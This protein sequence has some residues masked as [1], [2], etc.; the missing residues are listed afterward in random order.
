MNGIS[1]KISHVVDSLEDELIQFTQ[2]L[3]QT[4][5]LPGEERGIQDVVAEK[6]KE[7]NLDVD[8]IPL[9]FDELKDHPA[10]CDD[11]FPFDR[12]VNVVGRW[13]GSQKSQS[14]GNENARSLIL[15][16][17]VDVV[18]PGNETLWA[19]SPWS[20]K[21]IDGKL[22]GRGSCDMKAGLASGIFAIKA[23]QRL[24]YTPLRDVLIESVVG[25]ETGGVG[26][27]NTIIKGYT[28]DAAIIMEPTELRL[29][30][31]QSGALTFRIKVPGRSVHACMKN[32][33]ISSIDKFYLIYNAINEL[34]RQR[35]LNYSNRLYKDPKN[36]APINFGTI[37]AGD[38]PSTVPDE[39]LVE[40]RYGI[41]SGETVE[42][43]KKAFTRAVQRAAAG[44]AWL[45]D[46]PPIIE[47]F[48]GQFE[49]GETD[50]NEPVIQILSETHTIITGKEA[51]FQGVTYGSDLRLF[52]NYG[53][54]P[55]VL[56]GPGNVLNAHAVDE[57]ISLEEVVM[58][59]KVLALTI[60][61]WC[62]G[63]I[64]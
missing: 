39:L 26:T 52:T 63:G 35:H 42:E 53:N 50:L 46:H 10:F 45:K 24:G 7:L 32:K 15:N 21:I 40:G 59:T 61:Q 23:L 30:P 19:A 11:G 48:E 33:G 54:I 36:V 34:E 51:E 28:A 18:P 17:H 22:Y 38:W 20:G 4:P 16:G 44:D 1:N 60:Y 41:F 62:G 12:R 8:I 27:L 29:C 13:K 55:A 5:S 2:N 64:A 3:V 9:N 58:S 47:W 37:K 25:E 6:L 14:S 57:F 31:V 49:S 43:A 56:Y